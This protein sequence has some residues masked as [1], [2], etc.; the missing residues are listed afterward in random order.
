M[1][2][3]WHALCDYVVAN[4]AILAAT[5]SASFKLF[6]LIVSISWMMASGRLPENTA[7]VMSKVGF[8]LMIPCMLMSKVAGTLAA[9]ASLSLVGIPLIALMQVCIGALLGRLAAYAVVGDYSEDIR[10]FGYHPRDPP[11]AAAAIAASTAAAM[12][13][14]QLAPQLVPKPKQLPRGLRELVQLSCAFGNTLTLPLVFLYTLLPAASADSAV[15]VTALFL[16]GWSPCLWS[17]G[18]EIVGAACEPSPSTTDRAPQAD[19]VLAL[20]SPGLM[21][22]AAGVA[23]PAIDVTDVGAV[24]SPTSAASSPLLVLLSSAKDLASRFLNPPL[25]GI[26][27]GLALGLSP[28]SGLLLAPSSPAL[29]ATISSYP[30]ELQAMVQI[31]RAAMD[32]IVLLGSATL[33][34]QAVVLAASLQQPAAAQKRDPARDQQSDVQLQGMPSMSEPSWLKLLLP[35]DAL[36]Q[37]TLVAVC[38]VRFLLMPLV[39]IGLVMGML[40]AGLLPQDPIC[41]FAVMLQSAMPSAQ[42]LVLLLQLREETQPLAAGMALLLLRLYMLAIVPLT[43]WITIFMSISGLGTV[44][45]AA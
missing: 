34:L 38:I 24:D 36:E 9:D 21:P 20:P 17:I 27:V 12:S 11:K 43:L 39:G 4:I 8:N 13:L 32:V 15:A 45:A 16:A 31:G 35:S 25:I 42:N 40:H 7:T 22:L 5:T 29:T 14:P 44:L 19:P 3:V 30:F 18:Y 37:R 41:H 26:S 1:L 33:A 10:L 6:L 23:S 2:S 28:M